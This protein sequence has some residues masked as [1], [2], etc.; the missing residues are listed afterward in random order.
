MGSTKIEQPSPPQAPSTAESIDAYIAGLPRMYQA[1][2]EYGPQLEAQQ[3]Q[4][5][6]QY[7]PQ[8]TAL[9]LQQ[10]ME[11][12]P[13]LAQQQWGLQQ[14]Y[15]PQYAAQQ[16]QLQ[17]QYEPEAYQA[18]QQ[19]GELTQ[20]MGTA[21]WMQSQDLAQMQGMVTPGWMQEY[22]VDEA[23]GMQAARERIQQGARGA[24]AA[25]GLAE[26][27]M[28]A[29]DETRMLSEFELPYAMQ[30]EQMNLSEQGRRQQLGLGLGQAGATTFENAANRY[31]TEMGRRQN[32]GLSMAGRFNVPQQPQITSP[33]VPVSGY[34]PNQNV[35]QGYNFGQIQNAMMS[36]YGSYSGLYGSMYGANQKQAAS[37]QATQL[38]YMKMGMQGIGG[39]FPG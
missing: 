26:S 15:A 13:Q 11:Y 39:M 27:G 30:M 21:P 37:N 18:K 20:S 22:S 29:E 2:L 14:Q 35:M 32:V 5:A 1:Q 25:R 38:A 24:W 23:P 7:A 36:G 6:L 3:Y 33:Q 19:L 16:Q 28:S 10:Q 4:T 31:M 12:A 9:G 8:Y 34:M 17:Q